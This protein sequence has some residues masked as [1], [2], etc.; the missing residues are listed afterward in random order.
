MG[1]N[2]AQIVGV[3]VQ[4][5]DKLVNFRLG[6]R[7]VVELPSTGALLATTSLNDSQLSSEQVVPIVIART[8]FDC[9]RGNTGT[10]SDVV[11]CE[12]LKSDS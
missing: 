11:D 3:D 10:E 5:G 8:E 9:D 12:S 1:Q 4:A 7:S 6:G 2:L